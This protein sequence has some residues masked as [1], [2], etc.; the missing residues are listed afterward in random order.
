MRIVSSNVFRFVLWRSTIGRFVRAGCRCFVGCG[1]GQSPPH[2]WKGLLILVGLSVFGLSWLLPLV[3]QII[4]C[5]RY[6][7]TF[8]RGQGSSVLGELLSMRRLDR[9][10]GAGSAE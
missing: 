7:E 3:P 6:P 8:S 4:W 1:A 5:P 2:W 9:R 10:Y